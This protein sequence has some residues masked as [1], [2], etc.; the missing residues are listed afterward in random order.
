M[1]LYLIKKIGNVIIMETEVMAGE[2]DEN[3]DLEGYKD[4]ADVLDDVNE[5]CSNMNA[6]FD[7]AKEDIVDTFQ[8]SRCKW[9]LASCSHELQVCTEIL[10][11]RAYT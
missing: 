5:V 4:L 9:R 1:Q 2:E 11:L 6:K 7:A 8:A 3:G 10:E